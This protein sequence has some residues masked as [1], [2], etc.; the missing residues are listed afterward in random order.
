MPASGRQ[1]QNDS[2]KCCGEQRV[3]I[4]ADRVE[5]DVAEIEQAR[6]ADHDVEPPAEHHIGQHQDAEIEQIAVVV[7]QHR[8]QQREGEQRRAREAAD[9]FAAMRASQAAARRPSVTGPRPKISARAN[10]PANTAPTMIASCVQARGHHQRAG[11]PL[12]GAQ[13]DQE[14]EQPE[15]HQRRQRG[16]LQ[17]SG[18]GGGVVAAACSRPSVSHLL[19]LRPA[20]DA[21]RQED[22]HHDQDRRRRRRPCTRSRNRPTRTS[23]SGRSAGRRASRRAASRCRPAPPR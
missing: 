6:E 20:E 17:R 7:E 13:A 12:V 1:I 8:H 14:E 22:Q 18:D 4:G 9:D 16:V 5:R 10:A 11:R 21:G 19:D 2:P 23:R 15:R 3:G